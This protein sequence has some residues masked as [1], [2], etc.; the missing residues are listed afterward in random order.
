[1]QIE[2][3]PKQILAWRWKFFKQNEPHLKKKCVSAVSVVT[4]LLL[5]C[6]TIP[7]SDCISPTGPLSFLFSVRLLSFFL[8]LLIVALCTGTAEFLNKSSHKRFFSRFLGRFPGGEKRRKENKRDLPFQKPKREKKW[9]SHTNGEWPVE[10]ACQ[11]RW[12]WEGDL[13]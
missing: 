2:Q 9:A 13:H 7:K 6:T 10:D 1:M 3:M 5:N 12:K 8:F 4:T 11:P